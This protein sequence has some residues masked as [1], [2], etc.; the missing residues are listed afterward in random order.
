MRTMNIDLWILAGILAYSATVTQVTN[1]LVAGF[2]RP[3]PPYRVSLTGAVT[4]LANLLWVFLATVFGVIA[5]RYVERMG[6]VI[7]GYTLFG[8]LGFLLSWIRAHLYHRAQRT[9]SE[10][11]SN[12]QPIA[13]VLVHNLTYVLFASVLY[14][15]IQGLLNQPVDPVLFIPLCIGAVLPDLDSRDSLPG[16]LI[17]WIS[18]RLGTRLGPLKE[19]HTPAA[20]AFLALVT[21]PLGLL[22]GVQAW[23]LMPLGFLSHL[24]LDLLAPHGIMLLWPLRSTRYGVFGGVIRT[25]GCQAERVLAAGLAVLGLILLFTVDLG[26][27]DAPPAPAPS[28]A[29]TIERYYSIRGQ[30]QV[31]AY[32]DGSWQISGLPISGWFE[33]LNAREQ[34]YVLLDRYSGKVFTGGRTRED[35]VYLNRVVLQVGS[36]VVIKP[37]EIHLEHQLLGDATGII[38]EMQ[39]D[40]GLQHIYVNGE[41]VLSA[42]QETTSPVLRADHNQTSLQKIQEHETG[43]FGLH[44]L[45]AAELIEIAD[46]QVETADLIIVGT[47]ARPATGPTVTP[48]PPASQ[49]S[50]DPAQ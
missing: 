46:L 44:Y 8:T 33:I 23:Y 28:Y 12:W 41:L 42:L 38:Y 47:Y 14:L 24:L 29:Q 22:F 18:R 36:S 2:E 48:L 26:R 43:H 49:S 16:R 40:P 35:N 4:V 21:S 34:S 20:A 31:F 3:K 45:S 32:I 1:W 37:V 15:A 6:N 30:N 7:L 25:P 11:R 9:F 10:R 50:T 13:S 19:W 17:P 5:V 39:K 27:P